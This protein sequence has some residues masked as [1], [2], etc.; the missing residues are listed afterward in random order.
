[1]F[2]LIWSL[3]KPYRSSLVIILAAMLL[4][5]AMS[6]AAPW[7]L[8]V[9][10]DNVVGERKLP[11]W[12]D[13]FLRRFM[14]SDGKMQIAAAAAIATILIALL[15]AAASYLANYY[16]TSVGQWVANDLRLRTYHHLQQLSLNYY[17]T[18][19]MGTL[20]ST[21]TADVQTI[22]NFASSSTLGILVD[23]FTIVAMLVIMFWLNWDFTMIAVGVTPFMLLMVSRFKKAVKKATREV[24]KQQSNVV[25]V[26]QQGLESMRVVKAFGRQDLEQDELSDVSK[27]TVEA[28]LKA[29]RVKALLSPIVTVTVSLCTAF[30][31]WR[32]SSLILKGTMTTGA[33]TVFL[34]YLS[35]FFKPVQDLATM[36]NTI[37][38]TAVGVERVR[39]I[40]EANDVIEERGDA[41]EPQPLKGEIKF[42]NV[43]FAYNKDAPVLTDVNF[44]IQAG[45]MVGVVGPTGGGKS[46]IVSLIPRFYDPSAGKVSIDGVDIRDYKL[47]G[48]RNQIAYVL[49]ETV[50]FRGTVAENIAYGRGSATRDEIV[51]A[52][53]L[54][55]A[56]EFIAKM[57]QGYETMV[58]DR[59]DT[60]SG[61]QRQRIGIARA[62]IR[63][64]PILILDEPTAAL[65]TESEQL[66]M[67][68][69]ER[70]MKGRTVITIAHRLSTI[71]NSDKIVVLKGGVVA[72]EG[73][74]DEL[75]AKSGVYAELYHIQFDK[76]PA[77][78]AAAATASASTDGGSA[79]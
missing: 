23:M 28:A 64:N 68:A 6:V 66:V 7:P 22:Q 45:Q 61:G 32:S 42:E 57:P 65:D 44:Q 76:P 2:S 15:G 29:R 24:R 47:H 4:Q 26:V 67:E 9:I 5:T 52:A 27:A 13:D 11:P 35:K 17:N 21:I 41:R 50:L 71:R 43:A 16:T 77:E 59:G 3:L 70:L 14:A 20:L 63:N 34:S 38:Q 48:L 78:A 25:A 53:K 36:T 39:A 40:L 60:L 10:L 33:L 69:L 79:A 37:A 74:H 73:T 56:D 30:V 12:L 75:M 1:V 51:K 62:L 58:G 8:K 55:N 18:H 49:Q 54:A 72:E 19:E 46:T 31:L